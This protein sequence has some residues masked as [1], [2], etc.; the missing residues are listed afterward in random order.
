MFLDSLEWN[1]MFLPWQSALEEANSVVECPSQCRGISSRLGDL[2][3]RI[4]SLLPP[5]GFLTNSDH[6]AWQSA[7]LPAEP[8]T[9]PTSAHLSHPVCDTFAK[10][11]LGQ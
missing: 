1:L 10:G 8:L 7:S 2:L 5:C 6:Q 11:A 4:D 9:S 3:S